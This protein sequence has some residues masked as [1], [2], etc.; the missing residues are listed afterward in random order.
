V[1]PVTASAS[2]FLFVRE[3]SL[4]RAIETL[5]SWGHSIRE[6]AT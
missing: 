5:A 2:G 1:L 6:I 4:A 3:E